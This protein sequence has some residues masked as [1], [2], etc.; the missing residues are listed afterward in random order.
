ML[1]FRQEVL[2][3]DPQILHYDLV[4]MHMLNL[5]IQELMEF[6]RWLIA[7]LILERLCLETELK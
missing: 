1:K 7:N 3:R 2:Y 6:E 5:K 4:D